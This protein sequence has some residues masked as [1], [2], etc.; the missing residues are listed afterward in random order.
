MKITHS[1]LV[2]IIKEE[3][4]NYKKFQLLEN[5][6]REIISLLKEMEEGKYEMHEDSMGE[7]N[8]EMVDEILGLF[9]KQDPAAK[10]AQMKEF[11]M[12]HPTQKDAPAN[13]AAKFGKTADHILQKMAEFYA[14][15]GSIADGKLVGIKSFVYDPKTDSFINKT[16]VSM[17]Y[18]PMSGKG[19]I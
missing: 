2:Q 16:K 19:E 18:G 4:E 3:I 8:D 7:M 6:K 10:I 11:I 1:E 12:K 15:E 13:I 17:P 9:K 14:K 5:R